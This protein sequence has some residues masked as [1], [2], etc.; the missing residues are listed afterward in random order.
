MFSFSFRL[1][2]LFAALAAVG[3]GISETAAPGPNAPADPPTGNAVFD[4]NCLGCH[5]VSAESKARKKG[6]NLS[7]VGGEHDA[8]WLAEHV[9]N[10]KVHKADSKMPEFGSK[11]SDEEIKSVADFMAGLK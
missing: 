7:K 2:L 3:C 10:P 9:K 5:S 4:K 6:P 11:L 8:A 1:V